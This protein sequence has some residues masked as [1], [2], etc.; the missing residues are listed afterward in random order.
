MCAANYGSSSSTDDSLQVI[1]PGSPAILANQNIRPSFQGSAAGKR[2]RSISW[3]PFEV[4]AEKEATC[5][6]CGETVKTAGN[7]TNLMAVSGYMTTLSTNITHYSFSILRSTI[8]KN[9]KF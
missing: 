7:T 5:D 9:I 8:V 3:K 6:I 1:N 4:T 2:K